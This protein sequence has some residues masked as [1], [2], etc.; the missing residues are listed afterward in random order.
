[1]ITL[2]ESEHFIIESE[3]ETVFLSDKSNGQRTVIGDF[4]GDAEGAIIDRNEEFAVVFG[5][6]VIVYY[7]T[8]PFEEYRYDTVCAQWKEFGRDGG[9]WVNAVTQTQDGCLLIEY[10]D[11]TTATLSV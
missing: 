1:M 6:G 4:Y 10:E 2:A 9:K 5:C 3:Y 8:E 11:S 7:L